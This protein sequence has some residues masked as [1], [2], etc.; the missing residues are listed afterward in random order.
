MSAQ[1]SSDDTIES[2]D[3]LL[4]TLDEMIGETEPREPE[5][6]NLHSQPGTQLDHLIERFSGDDRSRSSGRML[7]ALD[8]QS[9]ILEKCPGLTYKNQVLSISTDDRVI[10]IDLK[11]EDSYF[12]KKGSKIADVQCVTRGGLTVVAIEGRAFGNP[13][14]A[15]DGEILLFKERVVADEFISKLVELLNPAFDNEHNVQKDTVELIEPAQQRREALNAWRRVLKA[16]CHAIVIG[17]LIIVGL[18]LGALAI[19]LGWSLMR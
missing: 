13:D 7:R 5:G 8:N 15:V 3:E 1:V 14:E 19:K 6:L 17:I 9:H 2:T 11:K 10:L 16:Y 18:G 4:R 12:D